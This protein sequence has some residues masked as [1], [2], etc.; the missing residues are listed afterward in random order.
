MLNKWTS[1]A[2]VDARFVPLEGNSWTGHSTMIH[3]QAHGFHSA[4]KMGKDRENWSEC[5]T[6]TYTPVAI[7]KV[8]YFWIFWSIL[9]F[10]FLWRGGA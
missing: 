2:I 10:F 1:S 5:H 3:V 6:H 8:I 4:G 7:K 9:E